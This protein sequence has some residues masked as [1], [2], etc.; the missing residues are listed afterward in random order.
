MVA[1]TENPLVAFVD[2]LRAN[3]RGKFLRDLFEDVKLY[4]LRFMLASS[5]L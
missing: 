2:M 3:P 4:L 1:L 5:G